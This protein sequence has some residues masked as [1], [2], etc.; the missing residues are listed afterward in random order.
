[1]ESV[2]SVCFSR[3]VTGGELF[4]DIVAR[5]Y[6]SEADARWVPPSP[7][8]RLFSRPPLTQP[9]VCCH[10]H[11]HQHGPG[12]ASGGVCLPTQP[13]WE[14]SEQVKEQGTVLVSSTS[15]KAQPKSGRPQAASVSPGWAVATEGCSP[16]GG[17]WQEE[18]SVAM[19]VLLLCPWTSVH[20]PH[21]TPGLS[22]SEAEKEGSCPAGPRLPCGG[23]RD[24]DILQLGLPW[25]LLDSPSCWG[26]PSPGD[27]GNCWHQ[28]CCR[29]HGCW[30]M[31]GPL[32]GRVGH[33]G[34]LCPMLWAR[35]HP[36]L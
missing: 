13:C 11:G 29:Q 21:R 22:V 32:P 8:C 2:T 9:H 10:A 18:R 35:C 34:L 24:K 33:G 27:E 17:C 4:E 6:Y 16:W 23:W 5:E 36:D 19:G 3:S 28:R 1:M 12:A 15:T 20:G 7:S 25:G 26:Q 31:A 14:P 30:G